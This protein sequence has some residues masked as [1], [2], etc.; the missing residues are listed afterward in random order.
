MSQYFNQNSK[1][2]AQNLISEQA[3]DTVEQIVVF[4]H[5]VKEGNFFPF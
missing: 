1:L 3:A 4:R 5:Q 2:N